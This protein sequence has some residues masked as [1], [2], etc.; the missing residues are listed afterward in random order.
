MRRGKAGK[1]TYSLQTLRNHNR[2]TLL[3]FMSQEPAKNDFSSRQT[4]NISYSHAQMVRL[5]RQE[6]GQKSEH[7]TEFGNVSKRQKNPA[8][9]FKEKLDEPDSGKNNVKSKITWKQNMI[10][11]VFLG[12]SFVVIVFKKDKS[13]MCLLKSS[14]PIP[15]K[16]ID[17]VKRTN[18]TLYVLQES[19]V[20]DHWNVDGAWQL[21]APWTGG[22]E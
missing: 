14:F 7:P 21:S 3:K 20:Y 4:T 5:R 1:E 12:A 9:I 15:L 17:V 22:R 10:S 11:E 2:M 16:Y 8:M 6:K 18:T 13:C 19:R